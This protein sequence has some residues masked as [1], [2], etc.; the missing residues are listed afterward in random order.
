MAAGAFLK[1][2]RSHIR[3]GQ[4]HQRNTGREGDGAHDVEHDGGH[5]EVALPSLFPEDKPE[6]M[7]ICQRRMLL[8]HR[9]RCVNVGQCLREIADLQ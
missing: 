6:T 2:C 1:H 4:C 9:D 3:C 5:S 8:F 7:G